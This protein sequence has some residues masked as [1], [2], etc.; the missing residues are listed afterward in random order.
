MSDNEELVPIVI[1]LGVARRGEMDESF[2]RMFGKGIQMLM[3]S[4]FGGGVPSNVSIT[5]TKSEISSFSKALGKEKRYMKT[6][7][8]YGLDNPR[9]YKDKYKLRKATSDFQKKTGIKWPFKG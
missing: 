1:D 6:A 3:R 8:K 7:A 9:T 2:L 4:M 5:G